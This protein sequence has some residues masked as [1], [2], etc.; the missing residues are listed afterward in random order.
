MDGAQPVH[1]GGTAD[2]ARV[3]SSSDHLRLVRDHLGAAA[4]HLWLAAGA[5]C[6][7]SEQ[8]T[9][10]LSGLSEKGT[11]ALWGLNSACTI[12]SERVS[13]AISAASQADDDSRPSGI[14]Y[15]TD[16]WKQ[17]WDMSIALLILYAACSVPIRIAFHSDAEGWMWYLEVLGSLIFLADLSFAFRTAYI[18]DSGQWETGRWLIAK[19]YLSGW[20]W[21]DGPSSIPIEL[22]ELMVGAASSNLSAIRMLR[23]FRLIR[24]LKLFK[25][26]EYLARIEENADVTINVRAVRLVTLIGKLLF[27]AHLLGCGWFYMTWFPDEP[28]NTWAHYHDQEILGKS[29]GHQYIVSMYWALTTLTTVGYGDIIPVNANE[30]MY[31]TISLLFS[32]LVFSYI[33]GEI[34]SVISSFDKQASDLEDKME[35]LKEYIAWRGI[36]KDLGLR[37]KRYYEHYYT[38]RPGFDEP[39]ILAGL[40]PTLNA[41]VVH[42]VLKD[43]LGT[44]GLFKKLNPDFKLSVFSKLRPG[45]FQAGEIIF[46][47]GDVSRDLLFL[48]KGDVG[49][50][51][52][53]DESV[54]ESRI[55]PTHKYLLDHSDG[56]DVITFLSEGLIGQTALLGRRRSNT[57]RALTDCEVF[58][59]TKEDLTQLLLA[60]A[61]STRI[62]CKTVL[63]ECEQADKLEVLSA[64]LRIGS[65]PPGTL[66]FALKIQLAWRRYSYLLSKQDPLYLLLRS[67]APEESFPKRGVETSP[68]VQNRTMSR[69]S[70]RRRMSLTS[71]GHPTLAAELSPRSAASRTAAATAAA[72]PPSPAPGPSV[73]SSGDIKAMRAQMRSMHQMLET[74]VQAQKHF[75]APSRLPAPTAG[76]KTYATEDKCPSPRTLAEYR[77]VTPS[78]QQNSSTDELLSS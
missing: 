52:R 54:V 12:A 55:T 28:G 47:K 19:R 11:G 39:D 25:I 18:A 44:L 1:G 71:I 65:L 53:A 3:G 56:S 14:I 23:L 74:L 72:A 36:P 35:S 20:F 17:R 37:L 41:E 73:D 26:N 67:S 49:V 4:H 63:R 8:R 40:N 31:V 60:D 70:Y 59:I 48:L 15:P 32:A 5:A 10:M 77:K 45:S 57:T 68:S 6:S 22:I 66:K 75:P 61:Q 2:N 76:V 43:N 21:V 69:L 33:I 42:F 62:I 7:C 30:V 58:L 34:G 29:I 16:A 64:A 9:A 38:I 46:Q 13:G 78:P 27:I 51:L 50:L 24:L